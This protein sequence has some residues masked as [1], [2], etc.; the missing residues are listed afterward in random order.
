MAPSC[1]GVRFIVDSVAR[2][3]GEGVGGNVKGDDIAVDGVWCSVCM[4]AR[5]HPPLPTFLYQ[6]ALVKRD[7]HVSPQLD[8]ASASEDAS[9][10]PSSFA[11]RSYSHLII[12]ER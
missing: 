12:H 1:G 2:V 6:N 8:F 4:L 11:T 7:L 3:A 10:S 9:I 5:C